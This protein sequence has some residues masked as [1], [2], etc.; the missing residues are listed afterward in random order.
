[1]PTPHLVLGHGTPL[2]EAHF[3]R[4]PNQFTLVVSYQGREVKAAMADRGRLLGL[5]VPGRVILMEPRDGAHRKTAFQVVGARVP[6]SPTRPAHVVSLDTTLP[7]RLV[8]MALEQG[9]LEEALGAFESFKSERTIGASRFDFVLQHARGRRTILEVKS[10]GRVDPDGVARFPDAP[11]SRGLKHVE[12]LIE[13]SDPPDT[14]CAL[15]FVVQGDGACAVEVDGVIDP[16]LKD[17]VRRAHEA[18]VK[19]L[20]W[21]CPLDAF[22][23]TWG[24]PVEVRIPSLESSP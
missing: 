15:L 4:R 2:V 1:M 13:L 5:L 7:N 17:G 14:S 24:A 22:G 3:V 18:G 21:Q 9:C 6:A 20:A 19:I 10:V 11:T 12:E 16:A 23:I 8:K